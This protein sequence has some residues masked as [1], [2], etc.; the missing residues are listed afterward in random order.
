[1]V[2][3]PLISWYRR[4]HQQLSHFIYHNILVAN[5]LPSHYIYTYKYVGRFEWF[6]AWE[7][8][9]EFILGGD[10]PETP[11]RREKSSSGIS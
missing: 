3:T 2:L 7:L 6:A 9:S 1:M 11:Q 5:A 4:Y 10:D 8:Q